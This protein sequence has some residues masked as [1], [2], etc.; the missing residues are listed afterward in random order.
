M[1]TDITFFLK[2]L[3]YVCVANGGRFVE[4]LFSRR[5]PVLRFGAFSFSL[6]PSSNAV[7]AAPEEVRDRAHSTNSHTDTQIHTER[8]RQRQRL[9]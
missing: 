8:Q 5:S 1:N 2:Y 4:P 6:L 7:D 3:S 9:L